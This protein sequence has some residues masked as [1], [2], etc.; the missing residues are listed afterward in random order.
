MNGSPFGS[1]LLT[2]RGPASWHPASAEDRSHFL[3]AAEFCRSHGTSISRLALQFS[4]QNQEIPTTLFSTSKPQTV[5][6][7]VESHEQ[8]YDSNLVAEVRK[9]LNPV[10]NKEWSY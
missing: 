10:L 1:G 3:A 2:D 6:Q 9:I 8:P 7:N 4:S 5:R